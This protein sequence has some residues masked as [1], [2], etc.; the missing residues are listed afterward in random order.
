MFVRNNEQGDAVFRDENHQEFVLSAGECHFVEVD[1]KQE[2]VKFGRDNIAN[3]KYMNDKEKKAYR[4]WVT[5]QTLE[6]RCAVKT[7]AEIEAQK[8]R[9]QAHFSGLTADWEAKVAAEEE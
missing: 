8:E 2:I 3:M 9:Q 6:Q 5:Q 7:R 1:G 4:K